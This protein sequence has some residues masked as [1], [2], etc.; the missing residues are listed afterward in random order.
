MKLHHSFGNVFELL[1][2]ALKDLVCKPFCS[3]E[4]EPLPQALL[5]KYIAYARQYVSPVLSPEA[6]EV[7]RKFYL[8]L[9]QRASSADGSLPITV[10]PASLLTSFP[11]LVLC[12][13]LWMA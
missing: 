2:H 13:V 9:R 3:E 10:L 5:K 8:E 12:A 7:I 6:K 4:A 11:S 1:E